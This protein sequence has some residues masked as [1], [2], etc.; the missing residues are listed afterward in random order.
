MRRLAQASAHSFLGRGPW[1]LTPEL[2]WIVRLRWLELAAQQEAK[3][4]S[5]AETGLRHDE[6]GQSAVRV[7][8]SRRWDVEPERLVDSRAGCV[9]DAEESLKF[10]MISSRIE[11]IH[12][13]RLS[14]H[15]SRRA[16]DRE[17]LRLLCS[18]RANIDCRNWDGDQPVIDA[19]QRQLKREVEMDLIALCWVLPVLRSQAEVRLH[20]RLEVFHGNGDLVV[21]RRPV[22]IL[23][24][25][26]EEARQSV[27]D[28]W[29]IVE[30]DLLIPLRVDVALDH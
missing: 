16:H 25:H 19:T 5:E 9:D 7:V 1:S 21:R 2:L 18:G 24:L 20:E 28:I 14:L 29:R 13:Y 26:N 6:Y 11:L 8:A 27:D 17:S 15:R 30:Y 10:C 4:E 12:R 23:D 3:G 22:Y